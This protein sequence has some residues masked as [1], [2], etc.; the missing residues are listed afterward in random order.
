ME[1]YLLLVDCGLVSCEP[2]YRKHG[3][4][5]E[6]KVDVSFVRTQEGGK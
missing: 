4:L 3:A 6:P 2:V 5:H 1:L